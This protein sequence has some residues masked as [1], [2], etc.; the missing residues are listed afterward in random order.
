MGREWIGWRKRSV[1]QVYPT[2]A[3][4]FEAGLQEVLLEGDW[5]KKWLTKRQKEKLNEKRGERR[6]GGS[7]T[8]SFQLG[9]GGDN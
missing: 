5:D 2:S 8:L 6:G 3:F 9:G 1:H 4:C 7:K